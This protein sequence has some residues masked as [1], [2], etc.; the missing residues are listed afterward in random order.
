MM[1]TIVV[2]GC[3]ANHDVL[4]S[5]LLA[6]LRRI[7]SREFTIGFLRVG[8]APAPESLTS[9]ADIV[10]HVPVGDLAI[11]PDE[12]FQVACSAIKPRL[13]EI[14]PGYDI[15]IWLDGDTWVQNSAG[16]AQIA[17][18]AP[19][20]DVCIHPQ[21]DPNYFLCQYP[22]NYTLIVYEK[23]FGPQEKE[24]LARFP[25]INGGVFG[26]TAASP[27]WKTWKA[28]L[29]EMRARLMP[30]KSRFFSDQIPLH[31]LIYSGHLTIYPLR[32][33]NNWLVLHG[34][35]RLDKSTGRLTAPSF[36]YEEINIIHLVGNSKWLKY[37]LDGTV[38]SLRYPFSRLAAE[39]S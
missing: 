33:V 7:P 15:Y 1:G 37:D 12:G 17:M 19:K 21:L 11:K 18:C 29:D 23:L 4:A 22:D 2:T 6:S 38:T 31:R 20:A 34:L 28:A 26:A 35:P 25:M 14:F 9:L 10:V 5:E 39:L 8:E 3:D 13:P 30:Q 27:L 16:L 36:P 24:K 32:A